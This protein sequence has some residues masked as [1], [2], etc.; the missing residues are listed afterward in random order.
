[1]NGEAILKR[2]KD[3]YKE[4]LLRKNAKNLRKRSREK[5]Y[6]KKK[7]TLF[8]LK[9]PKTESLYTDGREFSKY[10]SMDKSTDRSTDISADKSKASFSAPD[11]FSLSFETVPILAKP[12]LTS[13]NTEPTN[14]DVII[15]AVFDERCVEKVYSVDDG[16]TWV[17]Y[18]NPGIK[19]SENRTILAKGKDS[20]GTWTEGSHNKML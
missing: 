3:K 20:Y 6:L 17:N 7:R 10:L 18:G 9:S 12:V 1:M 11:N 14:E 2:R 4:W 19:V 8:I 15:T 5:K 16:I 13:S